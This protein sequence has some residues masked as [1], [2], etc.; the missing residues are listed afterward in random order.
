MIQRIQS[1]WLLISA[2]LAAVYINFPVFKGVLMNSEIRDIRIRE[3]LLLLAVSVIAGLISFITIFMFKNRTRQKVLIIFNSLICAGIFAAQY[4]IVEERKTEISIAQ[5]DWQLI[6]LIPLF[7]I[8]LL[9]FSYQNIR[10]DEKLL[11]SA[12]RMR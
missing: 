12:D 7:M 1:L 3:H 9:I 8:I 6:A 2:A 5:G 11:S 4:F 10:S